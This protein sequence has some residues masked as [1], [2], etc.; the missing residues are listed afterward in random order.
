MKGLVVQQKHGKKGRPAPDAA[1][2]SQQ[3]RVRFRS[4]DTE[5]EVEGSGRTSDAPGMG[6]S[7][8]QQHHPL[9]HRQPT[10][11]DN[12]NVPPTIR[13]SELPWS[14]ART[15]VPPLECLEAPSS[16][17]R[18]IPDPLMT[19]SSDLPQLGPVSEELLENTLMAP[20]P[21]PYLDFGE[22]GIYEYNMPMFGSESS[23]DE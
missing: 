10:A 16:F 23:E 13:P 22:A 19:N 5:E 21:P 1:N 14:T 6:A 3:R 20:G 18:N 4:N 17:A 2:E 7:V 12:Q 15:P 9:S 11:T 8:Q